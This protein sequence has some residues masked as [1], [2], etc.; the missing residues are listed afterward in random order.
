[1][2][3]REFGGSQ[4]AFKMFLDFKCYFCKIGLTDLMTLLGIISEGWE[5]V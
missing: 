4:S 5:W 1:M 3:V 2:E